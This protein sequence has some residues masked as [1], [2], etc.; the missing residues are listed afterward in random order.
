MYISVIDITHDNSVST[1]WSYSQKV[2]VVYGI[3][4]RWY[5]FDFIESICELTMI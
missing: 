3:N 5:F 2:V 4:S 1:S